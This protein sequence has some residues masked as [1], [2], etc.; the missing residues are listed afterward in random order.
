MPERP[1]AALPATASPVA[2]GR[3]ADGQSFA[4]AQVD[5]AVLSS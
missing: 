3:V 1:L 2:C 5:V 4:V